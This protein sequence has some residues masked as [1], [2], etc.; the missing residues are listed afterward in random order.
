MGSCYHYA[1]DLSGRPV[2]C[3]NYVQW[4]LWAEA[5]CQHDPTAFS[6]A[7][8]H[9][10]DV[11]VN[12]FFLGFDHSYGQGPLELYETVVL[13]MGRYEFRQRYASRHA[14]L[15]GH[16]QVVATLRDRGGWRSRLAWF[17]YRLRICWRR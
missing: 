1:L 13:R 17:F 12:T 2:R 4:V 3:E 10:R 16:D 11:Q 7:R 8:D 15:A 5:A 9:G 6:L 14:A